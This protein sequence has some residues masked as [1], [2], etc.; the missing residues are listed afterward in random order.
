MAGRGGAAGSQRPV[1]RLTRG[2]EAVCFDAGCMRAA[3]AGCGV[4]GQ[5]LVVGHAARAAAASP[6]TLVQL[7]HV[8]LQSIADVRLPVLLLL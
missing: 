7:L 3:V 8:Q 6:G 1:R 2:S 4:T 5:T